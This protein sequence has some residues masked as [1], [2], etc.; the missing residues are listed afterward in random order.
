MAV[1]FNTHHEYHGLNLLEY[2]YSGEDVPPKYISLIALRIRDWTLC[3]VYYHLWFILCPT[4]HIPG[5]FLTR[6]SG[7]P[8]ALNLT[9]GEVSARIHQQHEKYGTDLQ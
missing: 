2:H 6:F 5:P 9:S 1:K 8:F 7:I 4:R 3:V